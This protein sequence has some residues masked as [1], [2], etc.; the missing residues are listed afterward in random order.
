MSISVKASP[1][2]LQCKRY[3]RPPEID[4]GEAYLS[5]GSILAQFEG[6]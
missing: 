4:R 1:K 3:W 2:Q 6:M 5:I